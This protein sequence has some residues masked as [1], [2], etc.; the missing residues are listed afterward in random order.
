MKKDY[1]YRGFARGNKPKKALKREVMV[2]IPFSGSTLREKCEDIANEMID[3]I[4]SEDIEIYKKRGAKTLSAQISLHSL[5][6]FYVNFFSDECRIDTLRMSHVVFED[7]EDNGDFSI[8]CLIGRDE[9]W[10]LYE[11]YKDCHDGL[12]SFA[13]KKELDGD[14]VLCKILK[15]HMNYLLG[16]E[17]E[18]GMTYNVDMFESINRFISVWAVP[19]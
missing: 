18:E 5:C 15:S 16:E 6:E 14:D 10:N 17:T 8:Y 7:D 1:V 13:N 3:V 11:Q 2:R 12:S 4:S 9:M 19:W